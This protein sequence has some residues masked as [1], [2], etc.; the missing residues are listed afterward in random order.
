MKQ[1]TH[2]HLVPKLRIRGAIPPLLNM[3]SRRGT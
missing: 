3:S 2:L 1:T